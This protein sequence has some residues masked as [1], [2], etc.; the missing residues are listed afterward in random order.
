MDIFDELCKYI[1]FVID[2]IRTFDSCRS[3]YMISWNEGRL[4]AYEDILDYLE[5]NYDNE[6]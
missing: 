1:R 4:S 5:S 2:N 6:I 3:V